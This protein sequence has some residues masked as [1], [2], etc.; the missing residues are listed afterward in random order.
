MGG[1]VAV[2]TRVARVAL[3]ATQVVQNLG[4]SPS[5]NRLWRTKASLSARRVDYFP[6]LRAG[7]PCDCHLAT[8]RLA[9]TK[10][11]RLA[12]P[13]A[14]AAYRS[15]RCR[16]KVSAHFSTLPGRHTLRRW[17]SRKTACS[18]N[19]E[20]QSAFPPPSPLAMVHELPRVRLPSEVRRLRGWLPFMGVNMGVKKES[21]HDGSS[22]FPR[23][24][25]QLP[26]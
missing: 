19:S 11:T 13:R 3:C 1:H 26:A 12:Q 9:D 17:R 18:Q 4:I 14:H 6:P 20:R 21:K 16:G 7:H 25:L 15:S 8:R 2:R 10:G 23:F 5:P 24:W 22:N